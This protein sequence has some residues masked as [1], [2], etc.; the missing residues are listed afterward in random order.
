[1]DCTLPVL[2]GFSQSPGPVLYSRPFAGSQLAPV[3]VLRQSLA[4]LSLRCSRRAGRAFAEDATHRHSWTVNPQHL[5]ARSALRLL[6]FSTADRL[7]VP[8]SGSVGAGDFLRSHIP[9][10]G[11]ERR[12]FGGAL[13]LAFG[14]VSEVPGQAWLGTLAW[15]A[16][17]GNFALLYAS[18]R[19]RN[20]RDDPLELLFADT[21]ACSPHIRCRF[22]LCPWHGD[23]LAYIL[24]G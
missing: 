12:S 22:D 17:T 10:R 4:S 18:G 24:V 9:G 23:L 1:M 20:S 19:F 8:L 21:T 3:A 15:V 16:D 7:R 5:S 2:G 11:R 14:G 6:R 13:L